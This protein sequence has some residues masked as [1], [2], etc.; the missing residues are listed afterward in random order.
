MRMAFLLSGPAIHRPSMGLRAAPVI[1]RRPQKSGGGSKV[2]FQEEPPPGGR[3]R[4]QILSNLVRRKGQTF[5]I[6]FFAEGH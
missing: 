1:V 2:G 4:R 5:D 3:G 6:C